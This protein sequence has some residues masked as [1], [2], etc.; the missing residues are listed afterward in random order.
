MDDGPVILSLPA[1]RDP[2][3]EALVARVRAGREPSL[4]ERG[5]AGARAYL[6]QRALAGAPGPAVGWVRDEFVTAGDAAVPVRVY[7]PGAGT[8]CPVVVYFHGGGWVIGSVASSDAFC[9]RL[10]HAAGCVVASVDYPLAPEHPFPAAID[11]AMAAVEWAEGQAASWG[12]DPG[13][14]VVL[15]DS[16]GG[17]IATV[18]VRR[19]TAGGRT[20]VR[21]QVLAYPGTAAD[22]VAAGGHF[23]H[24]WPLT[25]TD[26]AW[27]MDQYVTSD[28]M[29]ADPDVAPL[30]ASLADLAGLPPTTILVGGCD[31][32]AAEGLAYASRLWEAGVPVDLHLYSGQVHG[33]LTFDDA[34]LPRSREAVGLVANAIRNA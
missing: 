11:S 20:A 4:S 31:P 14:L 17:N 6:E 1:C 34:I 10:S 25:D 33:F 13:R 3:A 27:F 22:R 19:L 7:G 12:A 15:G 16:A 5:V 29:R 18:A 21:R 8:A 24:E 30:R 9:R 28:A 32:I 2:D 23:G 26:R